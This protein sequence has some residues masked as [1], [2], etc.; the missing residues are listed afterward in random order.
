ME[1]IVTSTW[2]IANRLRRESWWKILLD[3]H[4]NELE[5]SIIW[6][7]AKLSHQNESLLYLG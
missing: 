1:D 4:F 6:G 7:W 5:N 2:E 3:M